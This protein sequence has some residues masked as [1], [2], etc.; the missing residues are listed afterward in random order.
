MGEPYLIFLIDLHHTLPIAPL[1]CKQSDKS[2]DARM[3]IKA[4]TPVVL[5]RYIKPLL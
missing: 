3:V 5:L 2:Y 4:D 1:Q